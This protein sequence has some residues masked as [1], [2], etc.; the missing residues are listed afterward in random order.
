MAQSVALFR[1]MYIKHA[2]SEVG[3]SGSWRFLVMIGKYDGG[4]GVR[5]AELAAY[6]RC[7]KAYVSKMVKELAAEGLVEE[8]PDPNDG[9]SRIFVCSE[10]GNKILQEIMA[11]YLGLTKKLRDGLGERK[12]HMLVEL[13]EESIAILER[14]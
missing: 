7:S 12:S 5:P 10:K 9:R 14:D 11:E 8:R 3:G 2:R 6:F 1:S 4:R 13:L